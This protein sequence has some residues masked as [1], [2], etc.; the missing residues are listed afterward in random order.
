MKKIVILGGG[1]G[2]YQILQ[3]FLQKEIPQ[4]VFITLIDRYPY[5]SLKTEFYALASGMISDKE[6][7]M[8]FPK[9]ERITY[10]FDEIKGINLEKQTVELD[11]SETIPYDY[12]IVG[13]GCEDDYHGI[14][15]AK[16]YTQSI[17]TISKA[18]KTGLLINELSTNKN[19]IVIGAGLSGI[20]I[21]AEIRES[22][23]DLNIRLL[24]RGDKVLRGFD[25]RI[26]TYVEKWYRDHDI[27]V[28][29]QSHV[30][31]VEESSVYNSGVP[32]LGDAIIWTAG[33]KPNELI[34]NLPFEKDKY[35]KV[36]VNEFHQIPKQNNIYILGDCASSTFSPSGQLAQMQGKQ[37]VDVLLAILK[38]KEPKS[39]KPIKLKG[40]LGSLG[41]HDGF[42]DIFKTPF[43]GFLP[44]IAK[45]SVLWIHKRYDN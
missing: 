32:L 3:T 33:V 15:G 28:T 27:E 40:V 21:A 6:A 12:L 43:T 14:I 16:E 19:V 18:R 8:E 17:Q 5:H 9:H 41:E 45:S 26:Q 23:P 7:R 30:E 35:G 34:E 20:E 38:G 2:G 11:V 1:Y 39:P 22:R 31:Y 10:V 4:D 13:L 44:R 42:G 37:I 36:V 25:E 29:H 24:D